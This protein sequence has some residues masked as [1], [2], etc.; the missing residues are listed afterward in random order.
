MPQDQFWYCKFTITTMLMSTMCS[1]LFIINMTFERFYSIIRPHKAASLNTMKRANITVVV[2][3]LISIVYNIP[4]IFL[5]SSVSRQCVP[6]GKALNVVYGQFYYW[7]SIVVNYLLPFVLLLSMNSVIIHTLRQRSFK[8]T[9]E[10]PNV[11]RGSQGKTK[12]QPP[13]IQGGER[14]IYIILLL[15]TFGFLILTSPAHIFFFYQMFYHYDKSPY[16]FAGF[17]LYNSVSQKAIYT[18]NGI[19]FLFYVMAGKKF[20]TDLIKL[21]NCCKIKNNLATETSLSVVN[22]VSS[23]T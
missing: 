21:F 23:T 15:V 10:S 2:C 8:L 11:E 6:Y 22:S 16:A 7:L 4:H 14:Q 17:Y 3:I 1:T 13:R 20:R 12:N 18:N 19:N 9:S 5:S